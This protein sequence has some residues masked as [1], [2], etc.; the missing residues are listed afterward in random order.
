MRRL[1][2]GEASVGELGRPFSMSA[3]A[4]S[5]H[6]RVLESA[7]LLIR[8]KRGRVHRCRLN[9]RPIQEATGWIEECRK[10]WE[11]RFDALEKYLADWSEEEE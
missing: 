6:V 10:H 2:Q 4:I 8:K 7:G 1:A 3:P 9:P 5:R 11:A